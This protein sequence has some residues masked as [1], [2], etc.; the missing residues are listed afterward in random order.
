MRTTPAQGAKSLQSWQRLLASLLLGSTAVNAEERHP[1]LQ[2]LRPTMAAPLALPPLREL[3]G[4]EE[5]EAKATEKEA[6]KQCELLHDPHGEWK[7][8]RLKNEASSLFCR[9]GYAVTNNRGPEID[10]VEITCQEVDGEPAWPEKP[11]CYNINDCDGLKWGCGAFGMCTDDVRNYTCNCEKGRAR[12]HHGNETI[13]GDAT[14]CDGK[15]CG[16]YGICVERSKDARV[17]EC[18]DGFWFNNATQSC[19]RRHCTPLPNES[20]TWSGSTLYGRHYTLTCDAESFVRGHKGL[21]TITTSCN[22]NGISADWPQP[23]PA[24]ENPY[25]EAEEALAESRKRT[26]FTFCV[27]CCITCA[28]LAA[29]LTLGVAGLQPFGLKVILATQTKDHKSSQ[30]RRKLESDQRNAEKVLPIIQDHHRLI[31]TLMMFNTLANEALPIFLDELVPSWAAVLISVSAVLIFC[32]V[33]PSA[34]FTGPSQ[35]QIAG[36]FA[37]L[38]NCLEWVLTYPSMPIIKLL[39]WLMPHDDH[40]GDVKYTRAELRAL[41]RQQGNDDDHE[42]ASKIVEEDN[43]T[44]SNLL[45][46]N[47]Q[48]P[49]GS[50]VLTWLLGAGSPGHDDPSSSTTNVAH[51]TPISEPSGHPPKSDEAILSHAELQ[52]INGALNLHQVALSTLVFTKR[53]QCLLASGQETAQDVLSRLHSGFRVVLM[54]RDG[55][56]QRQSHVTASMVSGILWPADLLTGAGTLG[57]ICSGSPVPLP[58]DISVLQALWRLETHN[59]SSGLLVHGEDGGGTVKGAVRAQDLLASTL[60][61]KAREISGLLTPDEE[62]DQFPQVAPARRHHA[63]HRVLMRQQTGTMPGTHPQPLQTLTT[64]VSQPPARGQYSALTGLSPN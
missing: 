30:D 24:C 62:Q 38:I 49:G 32:E 15:T 57:D 50:E 39:H 1:A 42:K 48:L 53:R 21:K 19:V 5:V 34:I 9:P 59:C 27:L 22:W 4:G 31:V 8:S 35:L 11:T 61:T 55:V 6:K 44:G 33:I 28:A 2:G 7:G 37:P 56:E 63:G 52:Q 36:F 43:V 13:C 14:S 45:G 3:E 29:G 12:T 46:A 17:C 51:S 25:L 60:G 54:L 23:I 58:E 64:R 40:E 41:I 10:E 18:A 16:P 20:G 47:L 26:L